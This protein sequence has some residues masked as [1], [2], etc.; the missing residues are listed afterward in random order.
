MIALMTNDD[1][2]KS[3]SNLN[4]VFHLHNF[5]CTGNTGILEP[6]NFYQLAL[7]M[8]QFYSITIWIQ[9]WAD[10][11]KAKPPFMQEKS[12]FWCRYHHN[13]S[14]QQSCQRF[15]SRFVCITTGSYGWSLWIVNAI[16]IQIWK[17]QKI[18]VF[19]QLF[20][21]TTHF[22]VCHMYEKLNPPSRF[23]SFLSFHQFSNATSKL[24]NQLMTYWDRMF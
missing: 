11:N 12:S 21:F 19:K 9:I 10:K 14:H 13:T 6:S 17:L 1:I 8:V 5:I 4:Y 3:V 23:F 24:K 20:I 7:Q 22:K 15:S 2:G 16:L 18:F